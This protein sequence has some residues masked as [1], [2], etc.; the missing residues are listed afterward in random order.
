MKEKLL[1]C[2]ITS[3]LSNNDA[4][5]TEFQGVQ[6]R[7]WGRKGVK[8]EISDN[9]NTSQPKIWRKETSNGGP[10][11]LKLAVFNVMS[12]ESPISYIPPSFFNS[13]D[14]KTELLALGHYQSIF[15]SGLKHH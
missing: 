5:K 2:V 8:R 6:T 14:L 9:E 10:I 7:T 12:P 4:P 15:L 1:F 13:Q 3:I 11:T